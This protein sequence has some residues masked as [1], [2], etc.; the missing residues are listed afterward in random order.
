MTSRLSSDS[1]GSG[2]NAAADDGSQSIEKGSEINAAE[3]DGS[4]S[5]EKKGNI[6]ATTAKL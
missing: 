4:Q 2:I 5:I 1:T 6:T 3:D